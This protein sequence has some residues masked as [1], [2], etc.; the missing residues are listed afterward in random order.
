M[1]NSRC[2][3]RSNACW[4]FHPQHSGVGAVGE[5]ADLAP[6]GG[7]ARQGRGGCCPSDLSTNRSPALRLIPV[8]N[9]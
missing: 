7:D 9:G 6:C 8:G 3:H 5:A 1:T 2:R 4:N